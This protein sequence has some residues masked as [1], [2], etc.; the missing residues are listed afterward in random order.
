MTQ[1]KDAQPAADLLLARLREAFPIPRAE[2][3]QSAIVRGSASL[4]EL[5][6]RG[7]WE[8]TAGERDTE[9]AAEFLREAGE[10]IYNFMFDGGRP[11]GAW[12]TQL[13]VLPDGTGRAFAFVL[14]DEEEPRAIALLN[15]PRKSEMSPLVDQLFLEVVPSTD[16]TFP[17][18]VWAAGPD[19]LLQEGLFRMLKWQKLEGYGFQVDDL[20]ADASDQDVRAFVQA[21]IAKQR[22]S[23]VAAAEAEARASRSNWLATGTCR[24]CGSRM[25]RMREP[26][27]WVHEAGELD[28]EARGE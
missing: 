15:A 21:F 19:E 23:E 7:E 6:G 9:T 8:T 1:R 14:A 25:V 10:P 4:Y 13:V 24:A 12:N 5:V 20:D 11:G 2:P 27:R 3:G 18:E 28:H 26:R 17:S 22:A 16:L